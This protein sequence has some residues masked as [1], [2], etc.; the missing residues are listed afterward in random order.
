MHGNGHYHGNR[1]SAANAYRVE[2]GAILR[3]SNDTDELYRRRNI[4]VERTRRIY[5]RDA[6]PDTARRN[7]G[8]GRTLYRNRDQCGGMYRYSH[9][10]SNDQSCACAYRV[11]YRAV[12]RGSNN[13]TERDRR[14]NI[15]MERTRRIF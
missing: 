13:T 8:Y 11:E 4:F 10:D 1:K 14:R 15:L 9:Y 12:L 2:Y 3:G 5:Q 7:G 6:E